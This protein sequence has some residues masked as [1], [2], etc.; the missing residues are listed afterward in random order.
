MFAHSGAHRASVFSPDYHGG[1]DGEYDGEDADAD[2]EDDADDTDADAEGADA[3]AADADAQDANADADDGNQL[4][5]LGL[6]FLAG[7]CRSLPW[8]SSLV[9]LPLSSA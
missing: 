1:D 3:N 2:G 7:R 6:D 9:H 8:T 5:C 4:I